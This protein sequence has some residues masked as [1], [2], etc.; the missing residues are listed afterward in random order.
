MRQERFA[1]NR[2]WQAA[3]RRK[4]AEKPEKKEEGTRLV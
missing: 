4:Q 3:A 1:P 2:G